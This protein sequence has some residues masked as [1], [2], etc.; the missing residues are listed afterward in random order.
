MDNR[1]VA[2]VYRDKSQRVNK[3]P[4]A[5]PAG[6][7][8]KVKRY[9][10]TG[11]LPSR[12]ASL[13]HGSGAAKSPE[14]QPQTTPRP[15]NSLVLPDSFVSANNSTVIHGSEDSNRILSS[16]FQEKG[17]KPLS[18]VEYEG[19]MSLLDRSKASV[20]LPLPESTPDRQKGRSPEAS[21]ANNTFAQYSQ[22][23]LRNAS[24][25]G[26]SNAS[27]TSMA[28]ADYRPVYHTFSESHDARS[29]K[30]VYPFSGIPAPYKK[31]IQAP[32][33]AARK[34]RRIVSAA[35]SGSTE[36]FADSTTDSAFKP[37]SKA[38]NS[39]LSILDG[40]NT[41]EPEPVAQK[42]LHNPYAKPRRFTPLKNDD[43]VEKSSSPAETDD[44]TKPVA[45]NKAAD[46]VPKETSKPAETLF[47]N[48]SS[49]PVEETKKTE[50]GSKTEPLSAS[51]NTVKGEKTEK[52]Q[53][54][55]EKKSGVSLSESD[56]PAFSFGATK[57]SNL[58]GVPESSSST[59]A[60]GLFGTNLGK[61]AAQTD[62]AKLDFSKPSGENTPKS[63]FSFGAKP[64]SDN[65]NE[66]QQN[67]I[68]A[69]LDQKDTKS[70]F[71]F[72]TGGTKASSPA[73][74]FGVKSAPTDSAEKQS[75]ASKKPAFNFG[76]TK[77]D[78]KPVFS[79]GASKSEEKPSLN[80][81]AKPSQPAFSFG[82]K[83]SDEK[84]T[85]N[86]DASDKIVEIVDVESEDE[87]NEAQASSS[88]KAAKQPKP[89]ASTTGSKQE[90][91]FGEKPSEAQSEAQKP[92]FSFGAK[93]A[94]EK[95]ASVFNFGAKPTEIKAEEHKPA[96][97]FG[98]KVE[99]TQP[100]FN[101]GAKPTNDAS[102][103]KEASQSSSTAADNKPLFSFGTDKS[104]HN[105]TEG[106]QGFNFGVQAAENKPAFS[107]GVK[108]VE[109]EPEEQTP[110]GS[111]PV[112][113]FGA[114]PTGEKT[115]ENK[116][117]FS[118]GSKPAQD[119]AMK[120]KSTDTKPVFS[121]GSKTA[122]STAPAFSFGSKATSGGINPTAKPVFKFGN[123]QA[124]DTHVAEKEKERPAFNFGAKPPAVADNSPIGSIDKPAATPSFGFGAKPTENS[125]KKP[126]VETSA[127]GAP[128]FG[129]GGKPVF[130]FGSKPTTESPVQSKPSFNF[131]AKPAFGSGNKEA[132][133]ESNV[134]EAISNATG[135]VSEKAPTEAKP[136][137]S[138][139]SKPAESK[140]A[141]NIGA[142]S[143]GETPTQD[144][145]SCSF[146]AKSSDKPAF[147]FG[148]KP[149]DTT[150][151]SKPAFS[152]GAKSA[153]EKT[154]GEKPVFGF[155]VTGA[156][157]KSTGSES[158]SKKPA[159]SFG[160][161]PAGDKPAFSFGSKSTAPKP[162]SFG[163]STFEGASAV[164]PAFSF[165]SS[166]NS[167]ASKQGGN[168]EESKTASA[169]PAFSFGSV[170]A[171]GA[172]KPSFSF[173]AKP[174]EKKAAHTNGNGPNSGADTNGSSLE[175]EFEFPEVPIIKA[176][177]DQEKV[178]EYE[179][180]F[181]F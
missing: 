92:L 109:V 19:V 141:F 126:T 175:N 181:S 20:T 28:S 51:T 16:F 8:S 26:A 48:S 89:N 124:S 162:L 171:S 132:E 173:G 1:R 18:Q 102:S 106:K 13:R 50:S 118:F 14:M 145:P 82:T 134:P 113:S 44:I 133:S 17:N 148:A 66:G 154:N 33:F 138:I 59:N 152:F 39:L 104:D 176:K 46:S 47:G 117:A 98:T 172:G 142:S 10:S 57:P 128:A 125:L 170:E 9:L 122:E 112:F 25:Y 76:A 108:N 70:A 136:A 65:S 23:T 110:A 161:K 85:K 114:K 37:R 174:D 147:A 97:S 73:F 151:E 74:S 166:T 131:G 140:P 167:Q 163:D 42:S 72:G 90:P 49:T 137:F 31:R 78:N 84:D 129:F 35:P 153:E 7:F 158:S 111:K 127:D 156:D 69:K 101:F 77:D 41:P 95:V 6:L 52:I 55:E 165:G 159:F 143:S 30:R 68:S 54:A 40:N 79:F 87:S 119:T 81:A 130:N 105:A 62:S 121:F 11:A 155:G 115:I 29:L 43:I 88:E 67:G 164:K 91:H 3:L 15:E 123:T 60:N 169:K 56:K 100:K 5:A 83:A 58:S 160:A 53:G 150:L 135:K 34:A 120:D 4:P 146:G 80:F 63:A 75:E 93:P 2:K 71:S 144:K 24:G 94:A 36:S 21:A 64:L 27:N 32:N 116:P 139:G 22:K 157:E 178:K 179:S 99:E 168:A 177:L 103:S 107:F 180:M 86:V 12:I 61:S 45:Q 149:T 38:A 96:F